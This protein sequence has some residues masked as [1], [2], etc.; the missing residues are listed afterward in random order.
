MTDESPDL[1]AGI[2][3]VQQLLTAALQG[4]RSRLN[5]TVELTQQ[6]A[7]AIRCLRA[8]DLQA[9]TD[10]LTGLANRRALCRRV[11]QA[12]G[13]ARRL[14]AIVVDLDGLKRVNDTHGHDAGDELIRA[15]AQALT[16]AVRCADLVARTGGDEFVILAP[17]PGRAELRGLAVRVRRSLRA[18]GVRASVG[19]A[20]GPPEQWDDTRRYADRHMLA[21]KRVCGDPRQ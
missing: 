16:S 1:G 2:A 17:V 13:S 15:A 9:H 8:A 11:A 7:T 21:H 4:S 18:A 14:G 3:A 19:I 12:G 5:E 6:S 10:S 20:C